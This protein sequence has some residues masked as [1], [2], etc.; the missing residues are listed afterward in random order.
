MK[1][2]DNNTY[3][4]EGTIYQDEYTDEELG[5]S[6]KG[7]LRSIMNILMKSLPAA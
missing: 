6:R 7:I 5:Q 3:K 4:I 1:T 2:T